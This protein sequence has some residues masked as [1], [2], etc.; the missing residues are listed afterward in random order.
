MAFCRGVALDGVLT[1]APTSAGQSNTPWTDT[2]KW[3]T[4]HASTA[5]PS[6]TSVYCPFSKFL[7]FGTLSGGTDRTGATSIY[8]GGLAYGFSEDEIPAA[9]D[10]L[11]GAS[12]GGPSKMD[13]TVPDGATMTL[14]VNPW[15]GGTP[16]SPSVSSIDTIPP[17][18]PP[19]TP[20]PTNATTLSW[21]VS[22]SE[23]VKGVTLDDFTYDIPSGTL[24]FEKKSVTPHSGTATSQTWT[25]TGDVTGTGTG[26]IGM[27]LTKAGLITDASGTP[28]TLPA[29]FT[30]QSYAVTTNPVGPTATIVIAGTSPTDAATVPF[31]LTFSQ[32]VAGLSKADFTT[33]ATGG[34]TGTSVQS[35]Q[36][37]PGSG[38]TQYT[39]TVNTGSG[40]G[41]LAL[42]LA[43]AA[44]LTPA[45]TGL[46]VTSA[47]YT[48]DKNDPTKPP[49][50]QGIA[51]AG[52]S[53]TS[54]LS[55]SWTVTFTEPV[56]G[57]TA[58]NLSLVSGG[59]SGI[60]AI[61]GVTPASATNTATWTVTASTGSGSGT[62]GLKMT[63][64]TNV[65]DANSQAVTNLPFT[66]AAYTV[67]RTTP[68]AQSIVRANASPTSQSVVSW[69][70]TFS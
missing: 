30:G 10:G 46:P 1:A 21:T 62:L 61:T 70:V 65:R 19:G 20:T 23:P 64:S 49:E 17:Q 2:S 12:V 8:T 55:V 45:P 39:V 31:T 40:S 60:P 6:I 5:F 27:S 68:A 44:G 33:V 48:I 41:T 15:I 16:Q 54:A 29:I 13:G 4:E 57:L 50:V 59:L 52:K 32:A 36:V 9:A 25:V 69:T 22:F 67:D 51:L 7:H 66:G 11:P 35:V 47:A 34:V 56:T 3:Y 14:I 28:L 18:S 26:V 63:N 38:N 58:A 43:S 42:R 53:P 37:V 24:G